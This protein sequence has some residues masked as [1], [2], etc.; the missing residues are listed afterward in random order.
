MI[1]MQQMQYS[2]PNRIYVFHN[3][4]GPHFGAVNQ[5]RAPTQPQS[6]LRVC[7]VG[8]RPNNNAS[9]NILSEIIN[10]CRGSR[11]ISTVLY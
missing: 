11:E 4:S 2:A 10:D 8:Q 1:F 3:F 9:G 6:W 7:G 5:N